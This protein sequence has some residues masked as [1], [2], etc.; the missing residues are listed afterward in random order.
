MNAVVEI[1]FVRGKR[2]KAD[3][4]VAPPSPEPKRPTPRVARMLALAH[5]M[6]A[7]L[8]DGTVGDQRELAE[9]M[10][11]TRA[12]VTQLLDLTLLAPDL[13]EHLL[14]GISRQP[15]TEHALR[16]VVRSRH[17]EDQRRVW[18]S[19]ARTQAEPETSSPHGATGARSIH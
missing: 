6:N 14:D 2:G 18:A 7:L 3:A 13:Q 12:R 15:I 8:R 4:L 9:L 17:W 5:T 1:P 16:R 10:G 11:L 19:L